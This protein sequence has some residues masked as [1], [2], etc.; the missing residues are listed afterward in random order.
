MQISRHW[1]M[2][3]QRYRLQGVRYEDGNVS[4]QARPAYHTSH[5]LADNMTEA[6][7][8]HI[9]HTKSSLPAANVA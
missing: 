6:E 3:S 2:N 7:F 8:G 5:A 9:D 4:L 1:R